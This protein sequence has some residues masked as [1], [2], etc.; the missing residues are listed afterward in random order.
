MPIHRVRIDPGSALNLIFTSAL[1]ELGIPPSKLSHTF[2]SIFGYD[3]STQRPIG[4]IRFKLQIGDVIS[5]VTVYAI[6][7]PLLGILFV[8]NLM[9]ALSLS[10]TSDHTCMHRSLGLEIWR[11]DLHMHLIFKDFIRS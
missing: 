9:D 10:P 11:L 4:K 6:K 7:T 2:M 3:G 1:E 8:A 5:K